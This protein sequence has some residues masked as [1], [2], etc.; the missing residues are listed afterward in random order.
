[1][2]NNLAFSYMRMK[3]KE[4]NAQDQ[5]DRALHLDPNLQAA[6][7]NRALLHWSVALANK[8]ELDGPKAKESACYRRLVA[9]I[10][11]AQKAI[12]L[13]SP[14]ADLYAAAARLCALASKADQE[15]AATALKFLD[16]AITAG[17]DPKRCTDDPALRL[18][19]NHPQHAELARRRF[20]NA[21]QVTPMNRLVDPVRDGAW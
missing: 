5:L 8:S 17:L 13:G 14:T 9:G 20:E 12:E 4:T 21:R 6:S 15:H 11:D 10:G 16:S 18:L 3:G 1:V 7:Y 19:E 2:H